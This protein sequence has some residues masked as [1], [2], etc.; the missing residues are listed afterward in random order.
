[1]NGPTNFLRRAWCGLGSRAS[2]WSGLVALLAAAPMTQAAPP[3]DDFANRIPLI[4][5]TNQVTGTSIGATKEAGEPVHLKIPTDASVWW[6]WIAPDTGPVTISTA[7]SDYDTALAVYVGGTLTNLTEVAENDDADG[8]T[9][10]QVNFTAV[11]GVQYQILVDGFLGDSGNIVLTVTLPVAASAPQITSQPEGS[12]LVDRTGGSALF[13]V[14]ARGSFPL[15]YQWQLNGTNLAGAT[16]SQLAISNVVLRNAGT[17]RVVVSNA[18]GTVVSSD[19]VLEVATLVANDNFANRIALFGA[20]NTVAGSNVN[21]TREVGEPAHLKMPSGASVWWSWIAPDSGLVSIDTRGSSFDTVLAVY[22]GSAVTALRLVAQN[23]DAD[24]LL[25]SRVNFNAVAGTAYQIAVDGSLGAT[26]SIVLNLALPV[27]SSPPAI[28]SQPRSLVRGNNGLESAS[29]GVAVTGSFPRSYQWQFNGADLPRATSSVLS[30]SGI[31]AAQAGNYRVSVSNAW[32]VALSSNAVL[33]VVSSP[34]NDFF[35]RRT[36]VAGTNLTLSGTLLGASKEPGEPN[37]GGNAG[38]NSIWWCWTAPSGGLVEVDTLLSGF[39]TT[40]AVYTGTSVGN[41]T[42][43]AQNDDY[44]GASQSLVEFFAVAGTRYQIAVDG[45][46]DGDQVAVGDVLLRISEDSSAL[47]QPNDN[48]ANRIVI[49]GATNRVQGSNL[50]T[51]RELG[52]P[53]H[54]DYAFGGSVWWTWVAPD[55]GTVTMNTIGSDFD[56]VLAV[57]TGDQVTNLT[58]VAGNDDAVGVTSAVTFPVLAG[59]VYQIAVDGAEGAEGNIVLSVAL[60]VTPT[61]PSISLQP[62]SQVFVD[63]QGSTATFS[64]NATGSYPI[65]YQWRLNGVALPGKTDSQLLLANVVLANAGAYSVIASNPWG[66]TTSSNAVL[67]VVGAIANDNFANRLPLAGASNSVTASNLGAS[68]ETAEPRIL[69]NQGGWS[70]WWSWVAPANGL[71]QLDTSGSG[72]NTMLAVYRGASLAALTNVAQD[73]DS[74]AGNASFVRFRAVAGVEYQLQVDG[75]NYSNGVPTVGPIVLNLTQLPDNDFFANR[76]A[77]PKSSDSVYDSN[78]GATSEPGEPDHAGDGAGHSVWWTWTASDNSLVLIDTL[79]SSFNTV[80]AVYTGSSLSGLSLVADDH[81]GDGDGT[82]RVQISA[83]AGTQYLLAV[84]GKRSGTG[85]ATG[86]IVLHVV[87]DLNGNDDFRDRVGLVGQTNVVQGS[88]ASATKEAGEPDHAGNPGGRSVWWSWVAPISGPVTID[89]LPSA[90]DT[91]LAVYTGNQVGAL[92]LVAQN[93]DYTNSQSLVQFSAVAGTQYQIAVDGYRST[94][95]PDSGAITLR[96]SQ[97]SPSLPGGNDSFASRFP[98][99]GPS[100]TGVNSTATKEP[101]E[102]NHGENVG[103]ASLWWSWVA[104]SSGPVTID[105]V[106]SSCSTLL[107]VYTGTNVANLVLIGQDDDLVDNNSLVGF[108]ATAGVEYQI[109]VDGYNSGAGPSRGNVVLNLQQYYPGPDEANDDFADRTPFPFFGSTTR[110]VNIGATREPGE[111][112]HHQLTSG[113]SVWWYWVAPANGPVTMDTLGSRFDTVLGVYTGDSVTALT[114]VAENDDA[115]GLRQSQVRFEAQAGVEYQIA[116]DGYD[117]EIGPIVLNIN[118]DADTPRA[119]ILVQQ[120]ADQTRFAAGAGGGSNIVF[121]GVATGSLPLSYQWQFNQTN[122]S[123]AIDPSLVVTNASTLQSGAYR[124]QVS[125]AFGVVYSDA[126]TLRWLTNS[127]NDNFA[128]RIPISGISNTVYGSCFG[129][130]LEAGEPNQPGF[131]GQSVWW[132]WVAPSNG[133]VAIDTFG[134]SFDTILS[135]YQGT[136]LIA[137]TPVARNHDLLPRNSTA[138]LVR[139]S[140]QAGVQYQIAVDVAKTDDI[141][142]SVVLNLRQPPYPS[143]DGVTTVMSFVGGNVA[144]HPQLGGLLPAVPYQYQWLGNGLPIPGATQDTLLLTN[145]SRASSGAYALVISD[146]AGPVTNLLTLVVQAPQKIS[147]PGLSDDRRMQ[148]SFR[149][150]DG[151][152]AVDSTRFVVQSAAIL[153]GT[154]TQWQ[155]VTGLITRTNGTFQFQEALPPASGNHFYRVIE[156]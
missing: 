96:I 3:N 69:G 13:A 150:A 11:A 18:W 4:G 95:G 74:G 151:S 153:A 89:T 26:G 143:L 129:A 81:N 106:G 128:N 138:S 139:F 73:N 135:V 78:V 71:V 92:S 21:A 46:A 137:L 134:S 154:N 5:P 79:G 109:A 101:G 49:S 45:F 111:P 65:A 125:N 122:I 20:T 82:S 67:T 126:A 156:Q 57:Y 148:F 90:I 140:A 119:P 112:N 54:L 28:S 42:L 40:L 102:P 62:Q 72:I 31:T 118:Q 105:T 9:T 124:L 16:A 1:M 145:L 15:N 12:S 58:L 27:L 53:N 76:L 84:D 104:S 123:G 114:L 136:T 44:N 141:A 142:P 116:V 56:T 43:I 63:G 22:T 68:L 155:A 110:G 115:A 17:Y 55:T 38:G 14:T 120:P 80:L 103:G 32:G 87:R 147:L 149:D 36:F 23:D 100:T 61:A 93:D 64:V 37:H 83:V 127:F 33:A 75:Y 94:L 132:S 41:L 39:N 7:G 88:N 91:L 77:F 108:T 107:G 47:A 144:L 99:T 70:L 30:V 34:T 48:F 50:N 117:A 66:A 52:E 29:F 98:L 10:S 2:F 131:G 35:D 8:L 51:T 133:L 60:P 85:P 113:A 24:G 121:R 86:D 25:T 97:P 6:S 130:T 19:A 152:L 146:P 59:T